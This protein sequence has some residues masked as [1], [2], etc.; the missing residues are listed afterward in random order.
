MTSASSLTGLHDKV[1][2]L[3]RRHRQLIQLLD[4]F[5]DLEGEHRI[6]TAAN[7]SKFGR[8]T[9]PNFDYSPHKIGNILKN[10]GFK[11]TKTRN[12]KAEKPEFLFVYDRERVKE[13][14]V[15]LNRH[16]DLIWPSGDAIRAAENCEISGQHE[17]ESVFLYSHPTTTYNHC[18]LDRDI[19]YK[20]IIKN[21][22]NVFTTPLNGKQLEYLSNVLDE[23]GLNLNLVVQI[24]QRILQLTT[25]KPDT[26]CLVFPSG[27]DSPSFDKN[28]YAN[29][30]VEFFWKL[31]NQSQFPICYEWDGQQ[32]PYE[33]KH[34]PCTGIHRLV[35]I[36]KS[37]IDFWCDENELHVHHVCINP[38]CVNPMHLLPLNAG[39]HKHL[40]IALEQYE[41]P[42]VSCSV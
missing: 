18:T 7:L 39:V 12:K 9:W 3:I 15:H 24:V 41:H 25:I 14:C 35:A 19:T 17:N 28:G 31:Q 27:F 11:S 10:L 29:M 21:Y 4:T 42:A 30:T 1:L 37:P 32:I 33:F 23:D 2:A 22:M 13:F 36:S 8:E 38:S 40:H 34:L 16:K 26:G 6:L 5:I 20:F